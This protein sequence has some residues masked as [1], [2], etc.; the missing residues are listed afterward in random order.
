MKSHNIGA[1]MQPWQ[2]SRSP[3]YFYNKEKESHG[4][5]ATTTTTGTTAT[6]SQVSSVLTRYS[7]KAGEI[8]SYMEAVENIEIDIDPADECDSDEGDI[9]MMEAIIDHIEG[10][11]KELEMKINNEFDM[12]L[13]ALNERRKSLLLEVESEKQ[14]KLNRLRDKRRHYARS[15]SCD[16]NESVTVSYRSSDDSILDTQ[17]DARTIENLRPLQCGDM[18]LICE[19]TLYERLKSYGKIESCLAS[20][21]HSEAKGFGLN[22]SFVGEEASFQV[23]T[24]NSAMERAFSTEDHI[25]VTVKGPSDHIAT[26]VI[27]T[28]NNGVHSVKYTP[29]I[30]GQY[31]IHVLV[32]NFELLESPFSC[33]VLSKETL[34]FEQSSDVI[35]GIY[36]DWVLNKEETSALLENND[37]SGAVIF[38]TRSFSKGKHGWK[39]KFTSAC[40]GVDISIGV[41]QKTRIIDIDTQHTCTFRLSHIQHHSPRRN[42]ASQRKMSTFQR[43]TRTFFVLLDMDEVLLTIIC[44]ESEERKEI[45]IPTNTE[46]YP[47]VFMVHQCKQT[48][49]PRPLIAFS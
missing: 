15:F 31:K 40:T 28:K 13:L 1:N 20:G 25:K 7:R 17:R 35:A 8:G 23:V 33:E 45:K 44:C 12:I 5:N 46:L 27:S 22:Y 11:A 4:G 10:N 30:T 48:V 29:T 42:K 14:K 19:P 36:D 18:N 34:A 39:V 49:C 38:G 32:N 24:R 41:S 3:L 2:K 9:G 26:A 21:I 16:L 43:E 6:F 37:Q 47:C